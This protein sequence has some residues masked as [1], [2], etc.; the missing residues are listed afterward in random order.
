M[1]VRHQN[2][3]F[4]LSGENASKKPSALMNGGTE[5]PQSGNLPVKSQSNHQRK[6]NKCAMSATMS[7][8][9]CLAARWENTPEREG[10][11]AN[12]GTLLQR[13]S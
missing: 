1:P 8:S 7:H 13:I 4:D 3:R 10:A 2:R 11:D 12:A 9:G 6:K 5:S